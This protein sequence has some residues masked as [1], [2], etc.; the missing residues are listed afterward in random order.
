MS[1][2][3]TANM[4]EADQVM[5]N[6]TFPAGVHASSMTWFDETGDQLIDW[7]VQRKHLEFLVMCG[8]HGIVLADSVGEGFALDTSEKG[9]LV[10][11]AREVAVEYGRPDMPLTVGCG[12]LSL[13]QTLRDADM[14]GEQGADF[15]LVSLP[16][17]FSPVMTRQ[18]IRS[19]FIQAADTSAVPVVVYN[20]PHIPG[21]FDIDHNVLATLAAHENI[22]GVKLGCGRVVKVSRITAELSSS[23]FCAIAGNTDWFVPAL[24]VGGSCVISAFANLFPKTCIELFDLFRAGNLI[25]ASKAQREVSLAE[26]AFTRGEVNGMKWAVAQMLSYPLDSSH[27]RLPCP[28]FVDEEMKAWMLVMCGALEEN[29]ARLIQAGLEAEADTDADMGAGTEDIAEDS[30]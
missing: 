2:D 10:R 11:L 5:M 19:F 18:A 3:A 21:G 27:C 28:E 20:N 14:A 22:V 7:P 8:V 26:W 4:N 16:R 24:V 13:S 23:Q 29:E 12:G 1:A 17:L 9:Q 25:E 30:T 15:I 6:F